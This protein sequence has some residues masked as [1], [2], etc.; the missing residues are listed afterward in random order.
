MADRILPAAPQYT[1]LNQLTAPATTN[2]LTSQ[3]QYQPQNDL[4]T[5][6]DLVTQYLY[7]SA[8]GGRF[9]SGNIPITI[10]K[11]PTNLAPTSPYQCL[12]PALQGLQ[13]SAATF[14]GIGIPGANVGPN[15]APGKI[16]GVVGEFIANLPCVAC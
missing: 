5:A 2:N 15:P 6:Y 10:A 11:P 12:V 16:L 7:G 8:P 9:P 13:E 4:S 14:E 1:T 3:V